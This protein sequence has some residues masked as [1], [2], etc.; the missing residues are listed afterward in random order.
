MPLIPPTGPLADLPPLMEQRPPAPTGPTPPTIGVAGGGAPGA[1][2]P[3]MNI[4]NSV[5]NVG[6]Q[7]VGTQGN[8]AAP[9][10]VR[11][12]GR[13]PSPPP[14]SAGLGG[15]LSDLLGPPE[16]VS[17]VAPAPSSAAA[18]PPFEPIAGAGAPPPP[19]PMN[20]PSVEAPPM[21]PAPLPEAPMD[22]PPEPPLDLGAAP[23]DL[24]PPALPMEAGP[25]GPSWNSEAGGYI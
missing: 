4:S 21:E 20:L 9:A 2:A 25:L 11:P 1:Q 10:S 22:L 3:T 16:G 14:P 6:Q 8:P 13:E 18:L 7:D 19:G 24:G 17:D 15:N 5:V 23:L 12:G